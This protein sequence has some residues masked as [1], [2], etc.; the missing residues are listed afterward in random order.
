MEPDKQLVC[1]P[2]RLPNELWETAQKRAFEIEPKNHSVLH[3]MLRVDPELKLKPAHLAVITGRRWKTGKTFTVGF[4]DNPSNALR[5]RILGHMNAWGKTANM[6]FVEAADP[7]VRIARAGGK[8]GGYW[9]Y[10]GTEIL[11]I[12]R[13]QPTMNLEGFTMSTKDSEFVRVVRHETGHT[14]GFPHEHMRKELVAKIDREKAIAAFMASQ[15]WT[16]E[17]VIAQ[18]LTPIDQAEIDG[19]AFSDDNSIMCYEIP[20]SLTIDGQPIRGGHDIDDADYAFAGRVYPKPPT[21]ASDSSDAHLIKRFGGVKQNVSVE[22]L[23]DYFATTRALIEFLKRAET[24]SQS[25]LLM[26]EG[27]ELN[28]PEREPLLKQRVCD[29]VANAG[30]DNGASPGQIARTRAGDETVSLE[31]DLRLQEQDRSRLSVDYTNISRSYHKG[32][33]VG[34]NEASKAET[35]EEAIDLVHKRANGN[36]K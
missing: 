8:D 15:G 11:E 22:V 21:I 28:D 26:A 24:A 2:K 19:T 17:E 23:G 20:G 10:L 5:Q 35:L 33:S 18:V 34:M 3:R 32:I 4:L 9:S 31:D 27:E 29:V 7:E 6:R 25:S 12:D 30:A 36:N 16:R 13:D 1:I 14:L